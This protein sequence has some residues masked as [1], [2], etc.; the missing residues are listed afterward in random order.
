M[1]KIVRETSFKI[2][3]EECGV[4][5]ETKRK[6]TDKRSRVERIILPVHLQVETYRKLQKAAKLWDMTVQDFV[7]EAVGGMVSRVLAKR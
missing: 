1:E 2:L 5:S 3:K 6:R 7:R 4:S